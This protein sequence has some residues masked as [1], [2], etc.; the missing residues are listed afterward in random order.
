M[1][2]TSILLKSICI[3]LLSV[4]VNTLFGQTNAGKD[5]WVVQTPNIKTVRTDTARFA[6]GVSNLGTVPASVTITNPVRQAVTAIIQ[7]G[8]L[9]MFFFSTENPNIVPSVNG[10]FTTTNTFTNNVY[11]VTSAQNVVVYSFNPF[12]NV[13]SNDAALV[14]PTHGLGKRYQAISFIHPN[15][16]SGNSY[17]SI[18]A[19]EDNTQVRTYNKTGVLV[20]NIILNQGQCFQRL[21]GNLMS[22]DVTGWYIESDKPVGVLSGTQYSGVGNTNGAADHLDEQIVPIESLANTYIA[23]PTNARPLG[24][25]PGNCAQD[26]FRYV[27]IEDGTV[28]TTSPNVGSW[29][30]NKGQHA[31]IM[32]RT[33]HIVNANK[34][35]YGFQYLVSQNSGTP[36]PAG[37]GDPSLMAMPVIEQFQFRYNYIIPSSFPNNFINV[38]SPVGGKIKLDGA[39]ITPNWNIV[40]AVNNVVYQVA[41]ISTSP[42]VHDI[43]SD[44]KFG[45]VV[46][47]VGPV[48]SYGY[49]GGSGLQPINAGCVSGGPYQVLSCNASSMSVQLTGKPTCT[50]GSMPTA[51]EWVAEDPN[52]KFSDPAIANPIATVPG[53]GVYVITLKV[54][55]NGNI[56][57][58]STE[59][60][61]KEP[62]EGCANITP[63]VLQAPPTV[64]VPSDSAQNYASNINLGNATYTASGPVTLINNSYIQYPIGTS[65]I[66]WTLTDVNGISATDDQDV[67]VIPP[68]TIVPPPAVLLNNIQGVPYATGA[69]TDTATYAS[70]YGPNVLTNDA[71]AEFPVGTTIV[72]WT[73]TDGFGRKAS[74]TQLVTVV[75]PPPTIAPPPAITVTA[76]PGVNYA[77]SVNLGTATYTVSVDPAVLINNAPAQLPVGTSTVTWIVSDGLGRTA[78][79]TQLVTVVASACT[80][81][82]SVTSI[83][84]SNVNTGGN[85]N[86]LFIGYGAQSTKL[87]VNCPLSS[88]GYTFS[89]TGN[90]LGKLSSATSGAPIFTAGTD[91]G[92]YTYTVKAKNNLTGCTSESTVSICVTDI[93]VLDKD[94]NWDGKKVYVCHLPPGNP[95]NVQIIHVSVNSV[96]AHV[97]LHGGDGLG[98]SC[99]QTCSPFASKNIPAPEAFTALVTPN[100]SAGSFTLQV[101][102]DDVYT[103]VSVRIMDAFGRTVQVMYN[104][105]VNKA[106]R[107]GE[108]FASGAYYAEIVQGEERKIVQLVKTK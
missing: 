34:P 42:G 74:G 63:P 98:Q 53:P 97:P 44:K 67:V 2:A 82:S 22:S 37:I 77:T 93:R 4:F 102:S 80:F 10:N 84:S 39:I 1:K 33:P 64:Y 24:C 27:A 75:A 40:G 99:Q 7:P 25:I 15:G 59:I 86:K 6:I 54:N 28:I 32:T 17:F 49:M 101:K 65:T 26:V 68:P 100:P 12:Y 36:V 61:A 56:T 81:S 106:V 105:A 45:L 76:N 52:V 30:L 50:D 91:E 23:S 107:F 62:L 8:A 18:V 14:L 29:T 103:I 21:N 13:I 35:F 16:G 108:K 55:C 66:T 95:A 85:P 96:P 78:S 88:G 92:T 47:G 72:T 71:P 31:E 46:A 3:L 48:A 5:F 79:G 104:V 69:I 73:I 83:P 70:F 89:W 51:I 41:T 94:G 57:T 20:D 43:S 58:C 87:Q 60:L 38:V 19:S 9:E 90:H 11:H